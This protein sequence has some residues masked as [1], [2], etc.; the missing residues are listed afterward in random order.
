VKPFHHTKF[1]DYKEIDR[2]GE[3]GEIFSETLERGLN[4]YA[5]SFGIFFTIFT[6][7]RIPK[8]NQPLGMVKGLHQI[9]TNW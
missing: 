2:N 6:K 8:G 9:F 7:R 1:N 4:H 5:E 3:N